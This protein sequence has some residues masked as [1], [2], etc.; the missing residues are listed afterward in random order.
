MT[1]RLNISR[2]RIYS[3]EQ[4]FTMMTWKKSY[5]KSNIIYISSGLTVD[6]IFMGLGTPA[7]NTNNKD[8]VLF[9]AN[10]SGTV[11]TDGVDEI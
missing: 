6:K 10:K 4:I 9:R 3:G 2:H 1:D 11:P 5:T 8:I 7:P